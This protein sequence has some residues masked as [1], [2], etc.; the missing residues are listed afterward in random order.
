MEYGIVCHGAAVRANI[1]ISKYPKFGIE[2]KD[3]E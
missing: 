3:A 1:G 2:K